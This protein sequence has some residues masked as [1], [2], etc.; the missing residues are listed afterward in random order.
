M[1]SR[2]PAWG[3]EPVPERL[4]VLG[5]ADTMLLWANLGV[6]LL[7]LVAGTSS[8]RRSPS[9]MRSLPSSSAV[10]SVTRMLGIAGAIGAQARVPAM[11]LMRAPLGRRGSYLATVLNVVQNL[12][13]AVFELIIIAAAAAA[14]SDRIFGFEATWF[15]TLAFGTVATV[16]ALAGPIR[17]SADGCGGSRSGSC[18]HH[19]S[20]S[21]GGRSTTS[22]SKRCGRSRARG[23]HS[24]MESTS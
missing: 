22:I 19:S 24:G 17:S 10:S 9:A 8:S 11:V 6:S 5:L 16:L 3:I 18:S 15:W 14:L 7:V 13:W 21:P 1:E 12:G 2:H 23:S 4:R 20:I